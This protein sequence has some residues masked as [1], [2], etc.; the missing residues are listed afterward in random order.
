[1]LCCALR[2]CFV[3]CV[4]C[5]T[6]RV[7]LFDGVVCVHLRAAPAEKAGLLMWTCL[8]AAPGGFFTSSLVYAASQCV[9]A[10]WRWLEK[11]Y[12]QRMM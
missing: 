9:S 2:V 8:A 1:M 4:S 10:L 3:R 5:I 6:D 7:A 12:A 11:H